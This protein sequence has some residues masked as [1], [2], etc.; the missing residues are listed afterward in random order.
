LSSPCFAETYAVDKV[1][2]T[3][4]FRIKHILSWVQGRFD[5]FDGT[6]DYAP[7]KPETW[8]AQGAIKTASIDT[9]MPK[10][11]DHL[12]SP[13]FFDIVKNP[14]ILFKT[15]KALKVD[16]THAKVEGLLTIHGVERPVSLDVEIL[17]TMKDAKGNDNAGFSAKTKINRKDF[18]MVWNKILD[19]GGV[20]VGD[21]VEITLDVAA[22]HKAE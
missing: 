3:V 18:G 22:V 2:T 16:D 14:Q 17:G 13:D 5:D 20:M 6:I 12:R 4:S 8:A 15:T 21:E 10:R 1:H 7:G 11:D 19:N 9:N